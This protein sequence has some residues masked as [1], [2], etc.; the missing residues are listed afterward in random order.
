MERIIDVG[1]AGLNLGFVIKA[2]LLMILLALIGGAGGA[3]G[4]CGYPRGALS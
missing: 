4:R 2:G 3:G 1:I